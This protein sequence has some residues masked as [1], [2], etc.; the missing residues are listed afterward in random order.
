MVVEECGMNQYIELPGLLDVV[1]LTKIK[2]SEYSTIDPRVAENG[3]TIYI[4]LKLMTP[5]KTQFL[6]MR[7][8]WE[9][10]NFELSERISP[11]SHI[12]LM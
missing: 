11:W 7:L 8:F 9:T 10:F 12:N 3:P 1:S 6:M 4:P 2:F 5:A